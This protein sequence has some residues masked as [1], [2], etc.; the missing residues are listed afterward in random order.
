MDAQR[1]T[2]VALTVGALSLLVISTLACGPQL[3]E[4]S[5][6]PEHRIE[7]CETW[8]A[9]MF[10]PTC[11]PREL[12][13]ET[14]QECF[15]GCIEEEGVWAPIDADHDDCAATYI[16]FVECMDSLTCEELQQH[17]ASINMVPAEEQSSCGP[18]LAAQLECQVEHY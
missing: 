8:C 10:D 11:P 18:L 7:P 3:E 15:E 17:F 13:V 4:P 12:E 5:P 14:Q 9:M 2:A 16:P 6:T 1:G